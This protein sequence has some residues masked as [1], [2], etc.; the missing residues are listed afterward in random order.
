MRNEEK[1][2]KKWQRIA[3]IRTYFCEDNNVLF[4]EKI[5][6][7]AAYTSQLCNGSKE[8]GNKMLEEILAAFPE[9]NRT[10]LYFGEGE[11]LKADE[12]SA[13]KAS[14]TSKLNFEEIIRKDHG[15]LVGYIDLLKDENERLK[16]ELEEQKEKVASLLEQMQTEHSSR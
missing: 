11:M 10:W 1:L 9:V 2:T 8:A 13:V 15:L 7:K 6:K 14:P 3:K 4:A 12:Q 16:K 5:G